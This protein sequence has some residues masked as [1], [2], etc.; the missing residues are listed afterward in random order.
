LRGFI[1]E[2]TSDEKIVREICKKLSMRS[3]IRIMDGN[4]LRKAKGL[5]D[6]LHS[7]GCQKVILLKDSKEHEPL[8]TRRRF[9]EAGLEQ[10][11]ELCFAVREIESWLL[12]D[13]QAL[14]DYL[15]IEV[16]EIHNPEEI[17]EPAKFLKGVFKK[18]RK[19]YWKGGQV[20]RELARRLH[21]GKV[22]EKCSSFREFEK[23]AKN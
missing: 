9:K 10:S 2:G 23:A 21:L 16:K 13:E 1:V 14:E 4:D 6:Q 15:K 11:A 19:T 22:R 5:S 7:R 8:E 12:A 17:L 20:P 18:G 3:E